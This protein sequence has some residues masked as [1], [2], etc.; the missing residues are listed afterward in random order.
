MS[1]VLYNFFY[2]FL[3]ADSFGKTLE[4]MIGF[5]Y[6]RGKEERNMN[7]FCPIAE[8]FGK[9]SAVRVLNGGEE[10]VFGRES[11][12][13]AEIADAIGEM[14]SE[15]RQMPAFGVSIDKLTRE[16]MK[17]GLW[18]EFDYEKTMD[19][20]NMPFD[21]LLIAIKAEYRGLNVV[22][23]TEGKYQG[24]CFYVDLGDKDMTALAAVLSEIK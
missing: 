12:V 23:K 3:R 16:E 14:L 9:A 24:R 1:T 8:Y 15:A 2:K 4:K 10:K 11:A 7:D 22:R 20:W 19:C 18:V 21:S 6:N 5:A 13:F 17:K